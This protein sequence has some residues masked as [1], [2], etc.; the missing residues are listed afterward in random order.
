MAPDRKKGEPRFAFSIPILNPMGTFI[1]KFDG[2]VP[3]P[4]NSLPEAH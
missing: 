2:R 3:F 4:L 1:F